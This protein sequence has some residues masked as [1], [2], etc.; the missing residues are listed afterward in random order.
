MLQ[1][2]EHALYKLEKTKIA[3]EKHRPIDTKLYQ[4]TFNYFKFHAI[5]YF[6]Q[7]VWDYSR[8][9][10][11]DTAH[12]KAVQKYFLKSFYSKTNKMKYNLYI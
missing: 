8:T 4:P 3:F 11:Y 5:N 12:S 1:Y 6:V 7:Y 10:N 9:V 2:M